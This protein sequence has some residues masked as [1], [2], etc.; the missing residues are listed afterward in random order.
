MST[1]P[2]KLKPEE[3]ARMA[4]AD[5]FHIAPLLED[6]V[7]FDT[8]T[9]IWSVMVD[10]K[11]YVRAYHGTQSRWYQAAMRRKTG[12]ILAAGMDKIVHLEP[13]AGDINEKIDLAYRDKYRDSPYLQ[14]MISDQAKEAT[15]R[16]L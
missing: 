4:E 5:D 2:E 9:W 3:I 10:R 8:P 6:G 14:S 16:V 7:T 1:N 12:R 15:V 11:L 13:V